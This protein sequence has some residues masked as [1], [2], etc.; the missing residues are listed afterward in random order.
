[1]GYCTLVYGRLCTSTS[2]ALVVSTARVMRLL[3]T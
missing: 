3:S 1:M 2:E